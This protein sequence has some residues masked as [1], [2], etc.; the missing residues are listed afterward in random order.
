MHVLPVS[1]ITTRE[2]FQ[3]AA[4]MSTE[5]ERLIRKRERYLIFDFAV[6][7]G[8]PRGSAE[9]SVLRACLARARCYPKVP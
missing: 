3:P 1:E 2:P 4:S 6:A 9:E 8:K 7:G 5:T